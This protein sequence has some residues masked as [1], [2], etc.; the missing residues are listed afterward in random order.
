MLVIGGALAAAITALVLL[1]GPAVPAQADHTP[2]HLREEIDAL[3][4]AIQTSRR[5]SAEYRTSEQRYEQ[6]AAAAA[7]RIAQFAQAAWKAQSEAEVAEAEI[8]MAHEQLAL[9]SLQL[10]ETRAEAAAIEAALQDNAATLSERERL[11]GSRLRA[12]YRELAISPLEMLLGSRSLTDFI[13]KVDGLVFMSRDDARLAAQLRKLR[14]VRETELA[15]SEQKRKEL[16]ALEGQIAQR[17][18]LLEAQRAQYEDL[19]RTTAA[20]GLNAETARAAAATSAASAR[21]AASAAAREALELERQQ[22]E[23]RERLA[24]SLQ[25]GG[26][27]WTG[28]TLVTWPLRGTL[29]SWFGPRWGSWHNGLDIA[30]PYYKPIVAAAAG[31]VQVVGKPYLAWGDSATVVII[32]HAGNFSTL[33]GHLDDSVRPPVV[34]VGQYVQAGQVIGYNGSTGFSTG[35]HVHFMTIL[36]GKAVDPLPFLP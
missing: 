31:T 30:G 21:E 20:A 28:G 25:D 16:Q 9:T 11:Y 6:A 36:D 32:K 26:G 4:K 35:P 33:Y 23:A 7:E 13:D 34:A 8:A 15:A 18:P 1:V 5:A 12:A 22:D 3:E 27:R 17:V 14:S 10:E 24:A 29:T 19:R 2:Q